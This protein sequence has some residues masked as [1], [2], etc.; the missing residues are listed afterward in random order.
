LDHQISHTRPKGYQKKLGN[1]KDLLT[2]R[3][4]LPPEGT[5]KLWKINDKTLED[6]TDVG[7]TKFTLR[8]M[9]TGF[10]D[11]PIEVFITMNHYFS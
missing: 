7:E 5:T 4:I 6:Q 10:N 9:G 8:F 3:V 1:S 11:Q 2:D